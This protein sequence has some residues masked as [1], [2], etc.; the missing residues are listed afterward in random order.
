MRELLAALAWRRH[1]F[2]ATVGPWR[3]IRDRQMVCLRDVADE[4]TGDHLAEH[5]WCRAEDR[6][7]LGDAATGDRVACRATVRPYRRAGTR[8]GGCGG[9][10]Y[11]LTGLRQVRP[12]IEEDHPMR[13]ATTYLAQAME[14][15]RGENPRGD[16]YRTIPPEKLLRML[17]QNVAELELAYQYDNDIPDKLADVANYCAFLLHNHIA[18]QS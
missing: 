12:A 9:T 2:V 10:D 7:I 4:A 18:G 11:H 16:L 1:R 17:K 3:V 14:K 5:V 13:D 6:A 15:A 8:Q